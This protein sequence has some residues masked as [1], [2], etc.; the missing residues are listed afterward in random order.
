MGGMRL[1][2]WLSWLAIVG[3]LLHAGAVVRHNASMLGTALA[4]VSQS[5][6]AKNYSVLDESGNVIIA[7]AICHGNG[8][9]DGSHDESQADKPRCPVC[10]GYVTAVA[11]DA[12]SACASIARLLTIADVVVIATL[13]HTPDVHHVVPPQRGPPAAV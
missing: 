10:S 5:A 13:A 2:H 8:F 1:K 12:P 7:G 11:I 4:A 3:M 6:P 9:D